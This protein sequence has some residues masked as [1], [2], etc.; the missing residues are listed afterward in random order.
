MGLKLSS[1]ILGVYGRTWVAYRYKQLSKDDL[2]VWAAKANLS[3]ELWIAS[4]TL[5]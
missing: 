2:L 4:T 5:Y 3:K 1:D